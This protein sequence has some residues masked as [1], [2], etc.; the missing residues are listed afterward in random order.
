MMID[1]Q[2]QLLQS[3]VPL[4]R[5]NTEKRPTS[6]GMGCLADYRGHRLLLTVEHTTGD[7]G[8]W[9]IQ[10]ESE[11]DK[12]RTQLYGLGNTLNFLSKVSLLTGTEEMI[13]FAYAEIPATLKAVRQDISDVAGKTIRQWP[14]T[15]FNLLILTCK[16]RQKTY[17][18]SP[19]S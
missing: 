6:S 5:L 16:R 2:T 19:D 4:C 13:D 10:I 17:S 14:V 1:R 12:G 7:G 3:S 8:N 15:V 9:A 18:A 11:P